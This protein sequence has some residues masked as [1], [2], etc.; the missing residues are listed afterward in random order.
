MVKNVHGFVTNTD[1]PDLPENY[2]LRTRGFRYGMPGVLAERDYG[3]KHL[4][5][6]Y[7]STNLALPA[8]TIYDAYTLYD[9]TDGTEY[10]IILGTDTGNKIRIYVYDGA[11]IELTRRLTAVI[12][13]ASIGATDT[14]VLIDTIKENGVN[15]SISA[16]ELIG[17]I[18]VNT[19][20]TSAEVAI[21]AA[22]AATPIEITTSAVHGRATG[23]IVLIRDVQGNSAANGYWKITYVST[24]KFTLD[25]SAGTVAYTTGGT[26]QVRPGVVRLT[27]NGTGSITAQNYLGSDGLNWKT[28]DALTL[29]RCGA[30][31]SA[32]D[33]TTTLSFSRFNGVETQRKSNLYVSST[34]PGTAVLDPQRPLQIMKRAARS[35]FYSSSGASL[36]TPQETFQAGWYV[37]PGGGLCTDFNQCGTPDSPIVPASGSQ[38]VLVSD[39]DETDPWMKAVFA[40]TD[41]TL[42]LDIIHKYYYVTL[43]YG[44]YQESDPVIRMC[45][46]ASDTTHTPAVAMNFF[47]NS[48]KMHKEIVGINV[49]EAKVTIATVAAQGNLILGD[50]SYLHNDY[51]PFNRVRENS[52]VGSFDAP[53]TGDRGGMLWTNNANGDGGDLSN[54]NS[55][56]GHAI[57]K[58]RSILT[59]RYFAVGSRS[60]GS[61]VCV[62]Q[63]DQ[64]IRLSAYDGFG[65]HQDDNFPDV[66]VDNSGTR[67]KVQLIGHGELI[68]LS[69]VNDNVVAFKSKE[70][71]VIDLQSGISRLIP[72]DV[73]SRRSI[74]STPY[75]LVWAGESGIYI[76][77]IDG[78]LPSL[79]NEDWVNF[80]DGRLTNGSGNQYITRANRSLVLSGYDPTYREAWFHIPC[81]Q[82][83]GTSSEFLCFRYSF[84]RK[85]WNVRKLAIDVTAGSNSAVMAF[86]TKSGQLTLAY[87]SGIL[88]YPNRTG[89]YPYQDKVTSADG[90][91]AGFETSQTLHIGSLYT[92][93]GHF[94]PEDIL[95]D[96]TGASAN[97]RKFDLKLYAN[98]ET[99]AFDSK[100]VA[101]DA[102]MP[103]HGIEPRGPLERL[104]V[105]MGLPATNIGDFKNW[106]IS[107]MA[108]GVV[109][110]P[111]VGNQ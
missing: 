25:G 35:M 102:S 58:D 66:S 33:I 14:S 59:P 24:T 80:Y 36:N 38:V 46:A 103:R 30:F 91:G 4:Y 67:Q 29:Y 85:S 28:G 47:V 56:L 110:A 52:Q 15:A 100:T 77:R 41:G 21:S 104:R 87:T 11:W 81:V 73:L 27:A 88:T 106:L 12:N 107:T 51:I 23:D 97:S 92:I 76:M 44:D 16:N 105:E 6:T 13:D 43:V 70:I 63:S 90:A 84:E 22:T 82:E 108:L 5:A 10:D 32:F 57:D 8:V 62:D 71:E 17:W 101:I 39:G 7:P 54:I 98:K 83:S 74:L 48:A 55:N 69:V 53:Q 9:P 75:G 3:T 40:V 78:S 111:A 99:S 72:A 68:G 61:V 96:F 37:E 42:G 50:S 109:Q 31:R 20:Q 18:A 1:T 79:L 34:V 94:I 64:M 93:L 19:T 2:A 60:Q 86:G 65:V 95:L 49:Y 89:A 26:M 45:A